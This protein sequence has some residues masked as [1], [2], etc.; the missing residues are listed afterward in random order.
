MNRYLIGFFA[1]AGL[2]ILLAVLLLTHSTKPKTTP[3]PINF[4]TYAYSSSEVTV[5]ID[6]PIVAN[7]SHNSI[8]VSVNKDSASYSLIQGY[9][10]NVISSKIFN[11]TQNSYKNFLYSLYYAGYTEGELLSGFPNNIGLCSSGTKYDYYLY[12]NGQ[13][14]QHFWTTNCPG[15]PKTYLGNQPQTLSLFEAQI[16]NFG[17]LSQNTN[18]NGL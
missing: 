15:T 13:T 3:K 14:I 17:T 7:E 16:P 4:S 5:N 2:G 9:D 1:L 18:I 8:I 6:G 11:N 12:N 10:G